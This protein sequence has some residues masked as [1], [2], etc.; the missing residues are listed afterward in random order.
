M[1]AA[2]Y[3]KFNNLQKSDSLRWFREFVER[4]KENFVN[5]SN[6]LDVGCGSGDTLVAVL[7]NFDPQPQRVIGI[8]LSSDMIEFASKNFK[9]DVLSFIVLKAEDE[10][11]DKNLQPE[12]FELVTSFFCYHWVHNQK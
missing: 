3:T 8:D 2:L 9:N 11:F 6:I 1:E 7:G 5:C 12:S 10:N 4:Y